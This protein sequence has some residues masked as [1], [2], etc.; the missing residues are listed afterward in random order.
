MSHAFQ[1]T[2]V[3]TREHE[4]IS[5]RSDYNNFSVHTV[6]EMYTLV[7]AVLYTEW[8]EIRA[9]VVHSVTAF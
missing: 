4:V 5:G 1:I 9:Q 8:K 3:E 6:S 2:Q 7:L